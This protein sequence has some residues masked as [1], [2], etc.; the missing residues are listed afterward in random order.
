MLDGT[1]TPGSAA[2]VVNID[3]WC[4]SR[5]CAGC[6]SRLKDNLRGSWKLKGC[7]NPRCQRTAWN[8]DV[9]AAINIERRLQETL[10]DF[11]GGDTDMQRWR[12]RRGMS[13]P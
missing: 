4:T 3:E 12:H 13:T 9:N 10:M 5:T 11:A 2:Q 6:H 7:V 1:D 8:R